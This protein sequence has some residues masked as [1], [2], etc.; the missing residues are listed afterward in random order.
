[1]AFT[2]FSSTLFSQVALN[3]APSLLT[4]WLR[5]PPAATPSASLWVT[6]RMET[7]SSTYLLNFST[8][9]EKDPK[10]ASS[11]VMDFRLRW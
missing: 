1:M 5:M 4:A 6:I 8:A 3:G 9:G 10:K 11:E 7:P 2:I